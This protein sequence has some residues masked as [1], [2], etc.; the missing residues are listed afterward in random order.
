MPGP[1]GLSGRPGGLSVSMVV[2]N[3]AVGVRRR[4]DAA[5]HN[6]LG[7][8]SPRHHGQHTGPGVEGQ[9]RTSP[10]RGHTAASFNK[11]VQLG[12]QVRD[13]VI[14]ISMV[15]R[16]AYSHTMEPRLHSDSFGLAVTGLEDRTKRSPL[17]GLAVIPSCHMVHVL[18]CL[19]LKG[20][21]RAAIKP[22][23]ALLS[24]KPASY[25]SYCIHLPASSMHIVHPQ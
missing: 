2:L 1:A 8:C 5:L 11:R 4:S 23:C 9:G 14:Q 12:V 16:V 15:P 6:G 3:L 10:T 24:T 19:L 22:V 20:F 18:W 25:P 21:C 17:V 7:A 13:L